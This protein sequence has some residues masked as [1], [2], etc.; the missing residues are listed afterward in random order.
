VRGLFKDVK[1]RGKRALKGRLSG[2]VSILLTMGRGPASRRLQGNGKRAA[3]DGEL[4]NLDLIKTI[5]RV[6]GMIGLP[7]TN[8]V[9][10]RRF[11]KWKRILFS[12]AG[13]A[14]FTRLYPVNP[15]MEV[16]GDG[17]M[18]IEQP[19]LDLAIS[20]GLSPQVSAR[21]AR[22]RMTS[23]FKDKQAVSWCR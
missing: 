16:S 2:E 7:K 9:R 21:A 15:Q 17:T 6:T 20:T 3:R 12:A 5:R 23:Y 19:T 1:V 14:A 13:N 4:T 18:A 10:P 11:R 22:G 8:G